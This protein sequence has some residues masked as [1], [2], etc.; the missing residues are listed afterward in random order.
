MDNT[1]VISNV[2]MA[3][4][5][6]LTWVLV[7]ALIIIGFILGKIYKTRFY[8]VVKESLAVKKL[9][10]NQCSESIKNGYEVYRRHLELWCYARH[11]ISI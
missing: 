4:T 8:M 9:D 3:A 1:V 10:V 5:I 7:M 6:I 11:V 2:L